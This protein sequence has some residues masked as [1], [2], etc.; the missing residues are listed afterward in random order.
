TSQARRS[1]ACHWTCSASMRGLRRFHEARHARWG[2]L[3]SR[4][5][6]KGSDHIENQLLQIARARSPEV[7][8]RRL[9]SLAERE[10]AKCAVPTDRCTMR[11]VIRRTTARFAFDG[12]LCPARVRWHLDSV[13]VGS[14]LPSD[15][16]IVDRIGH[17]WGD[18]HAD[19]P[20][21]EPVYVTS[22][23][24]DALA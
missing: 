14:D 21:C 12:S 6:D 5:G 18:C 16:D 4:T 8:P 19:L 20:C 3:F 9:R 2:A 7:G 13:A 1:R 23:V 10:I 22:T 15:R 11:P 17:G 24:R